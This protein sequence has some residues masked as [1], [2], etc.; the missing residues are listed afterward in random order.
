MELANTG[1]WS[2]NISKHYAANCGDQSGS[3]GHWV[4]AIAVNLLVWK[5]LIFH[6]VYY[7]MVYIL[8]PVIRTK[9]AEKFF[10]W[11]PHSSRSSIQHFNRQNHQNTTHILHMFFPLPS[12][13]IPTR[14]R[15]FNMFHLPQIKTVIRYYTISFCSR[16]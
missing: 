11:T 8:M 1:C 3:R 5:V 16:Q 9:I 2:K 14:P 6:I 4:T 13:H 10:R 15:V 7:F 12:R